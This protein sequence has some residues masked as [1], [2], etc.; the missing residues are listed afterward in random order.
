MESLSCCSFSISDIK[1][2][3]ESSS[4]AFESCASWR[5]ST[6]KGK[7]IF[8]LNRFR[9]IP[10]L[11]YHFSKLLKLWKLLVCFSFWLFLP[12]SCKATPPNIAFRHGEPDPR[13]GKSCVLG[14]VWVI[15]QPPPEIFASQPL[16]PEPCDGQRK[17]AKSSHPSKM[18]RDHVSMC[19]VYCPSK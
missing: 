5:I 13:G 10:L 6:D 3:T 15:S 9:M 8:A 12:I 18:S 14:N 16:H 11:P 1:P 7:L 4:R 19:H 2:P 17:N